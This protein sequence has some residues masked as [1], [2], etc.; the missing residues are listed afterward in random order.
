MKDFG[1]AVPVVKM[2]MEMEKEKEKK[3]AHQIQL[4]HRISMNLAPTLDKKRNLM[5]CECDFK[6]DIQ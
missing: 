2:E 4:K 5:K 1:S 6:E 3:T